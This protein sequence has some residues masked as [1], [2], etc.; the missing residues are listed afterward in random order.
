MNIFKTFI[1][2]SL[3]ISFLFSNVTT[4]IPKT[5]IKNEPFIFSFEV[6]GNDVEFPNINFIDGNIVD[7][8]SNSSSTT[9]INSNLTKKIKRVYSFYPNDDF[10][11]PSFKF[12]IDGKEILT[13][14]QSIKLVDAKKTKSKFFDFSIKTNKDEVFEGENLLLTIVFK[15]SKNLQ[16]LDLKLKESSLENFWFKN[17]DNSKQYEDSEFIIHELKYI[18]FPQKNGE[19]IINAFNIDVKHIDSNSRS[20]FSNGI[21]NQRVYSNALKIK[22]N[23]LPFNLDLIGEYQISSEVD[24]LIVEKN[25]PVSYKLTIKGNGNFDD[26]KDIKLN[27]PNVTIYENKPIIE[28]KYED[29]KYKG[30]YTKVFSLVSDKSFDIPSVKLKYYDLNLKKEFENSTKIFSIKVNDNSTSTEVLKL[31]KLPI[32]VEKKE[33]V[34]VIDKSSIK[35]K[36]LYFSFGIIF[37]LLMLGLYFY[38]INSRKNR[39]LDDIPLVRKVKLSKNKEELLKSLCVYI[40]LNKDLDKLIFKIEE[41]DNINLLKKEIVKLLK[42]IDLKVNK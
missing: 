4:S 41:V 26:I 9:I 39:K 8:I 28:T 30:I 40:N 34:K 22:V 37:T 12:I 15:Y 3:F 36:I 35:S 21:V 32:N 2:L 25:E 27:I 17:I 20:F 1:L 5:S 38:V 13:E 11:F 33:I 7:N 19:L 24:K 31:E 6:I 14:E 10:V 16:V 29:G 42:Q 23:K 18:L